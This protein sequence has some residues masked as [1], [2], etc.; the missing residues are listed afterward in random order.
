MINSIALSLLLGFELSYY[1]LI[2][3]T[4]IV[5]HYDSDLITLF[6]MFAGGII[7]TI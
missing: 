7:G 5:A 1:L 6:P 2:L 4:G 3:Q